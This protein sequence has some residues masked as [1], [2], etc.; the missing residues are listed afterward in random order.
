MFANIKKKIVKDFYFEK[1]NSLNITRSK[2]KCFAIIKKKQ[3][4][5]TN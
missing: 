4:M 5:Q 2:E 3:L 1:N